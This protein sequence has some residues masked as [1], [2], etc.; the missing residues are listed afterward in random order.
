MMFTRR[1]FISLIMATFAVRPGYADKGVP[2]SLYSQ[3]YGTS[4]HDI[5]PEHTFRMKELKVYA[6]MRGCEVIISHGDQI[7]HAEW[8]LV[9]SAQEFYPVYV[10]KDLPLDEL[11]L[12]DLAKILVG[13][14]VNW[15]EFGVGVGRINLYR[16]ERKLN[17]KAFDNLV[18]RAG[19]VGKF[20]DI[21]KAEFEDSYQS[22]YDSAS[23]DIDSITIGL[24]GVATPFLKAIKIDGASPF[25][26]SGRYPL[27]INTYMYRRKGSE[28]AQLI[29]EKYWDNFNLE[30]EK[31]T[32]LMYNAPS[33]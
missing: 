26:M 15:G 20:T 2:T 9:H 25:E 11:A 4:T 1:N 8:E 14:A 17:K 23:R 32:N 3:V 7:E 22:L 10:H 28:K 30:K 27:T 16:H 33:A 31:D 13:E 19:I 12:H 5:G 29:W 21:T 18:E 24:R 6:N